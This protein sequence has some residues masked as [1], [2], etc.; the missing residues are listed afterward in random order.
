MDEDAKKQSGFLDQKNSLELSEQT[1]TSSRAW[2]EVRDVMSRDVVTVSKESPVVEAAQKMTARNISC[3]VVV[4]NNQVVGLITERDLLQKVVALGANSQVRKVCEIM[5]SPVLTV[6]PLMSIFEASAVL[7]THKIKRLPV[8]DN[9]LLVGIV[10]QTDL[11]RV[12]ASYGMWRNVGELMSH[13]VAVIK[14]D[15]LVSEAAKLMAER[16]I[17][18]VIALDEDQVVGIM[19]E[20]DM[21]KKIVALQKDPTK[22]WLHEVMS[23]PVL[24]IGADQ[25]VFEAL[26]LIEAKKIRR[27]VV[28]QGP[29]LLGIL[30]QT[31]IFRAIKKKLEDE[32][33]HHL[34]VL[35]RSENGI[36]AI[37][38]KGITTY[39]NP[40][41]QRLLDLENKEE[42]VGKPFL[43]E[44]FWIDPKDRT[45]LMGE[46]K[47]DSGIE[48]KELVL[49]SLKNKR[50][51]VTLFSTFTKNIHGEVNGTQG[52]L[53]DITDKKEL[54][55][56]RE[57]QEE[58]RRSNENLKRLNEAKSDF[59]SLVS[60]ELRAPMTVIRGRLDLVI[61]K[62]LGDVNEKQEKSLE[63]A[64]QNVDRLVRMVNNF[65]DLS[66]IEAG[67]MELRRDWIDLV[68]VIQFAAST[69]ANHA[70]EK[71]LALKV[72]LPFEHKKVFAE[73]D[74]LL[75]VLLNL[76]GNALKFTKQGEVKISVTEKENV[77][78]FMVADTGPGIPADELAVIFE[79]FGQS[80]RQGGSAKGTGLGL[81]LAE[82]FV[83]MHG[84]KL[85]VESK[86]GEGSK[87]FFAIPKL[88]VES[89]FLQ[90]IADAIK[91]A[92]EK[93]LNFCVALL[94]VEFLM[95]SIADV[96]L[97]LK[98]SVLKGLK[99]V[100]EDSLRHGGD[101]VVQ[102]EK[103]LM[104]LLTN[105]D[106]EGAEK[107]LERFILVLAHYL[108]K[109]ELQDQ[110]RF[111]FVSC[112]YPEDGF[113]EDELLVKLR[114][115]IAKSKNF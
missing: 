98:T 91:A 18:C 39:V 32:E 24:S 31:D 107:A 53:Y 16:N 38:L 74:R 25:S 101:T 4:E 36:F 54:V 17:S 41:L 27:L 94:S 49:C 96:A 106:R 111:I 52:I 28:M 67:R 83:K 9:G 42:L 19:T 33:A 10:T 75:Q 114:E 72:E 65:L 81:T 108:A 45:Q 29:R 102:G 15:S 85:W 92:S 6:S 103:E 99:A 105:C 79:K 109:K 59:V 1:L 112:A 14:K 69:F 63:L 7:E 71:K 13:A 47:R 8:V 61:S 21:M 3:S 2:L 55:A 77:F 64:I 86:L 44:R 70:Q 104:V 57:T 66:K 34:R 88:S 89:V 97:E 90:T 115:S 43:P 76:V 11:T 78:E 51:Y 113:S 80:K 48:I 12:L 20:R 40:A 30:T 110:I 37:D 68:R 58:L 82:Q 26:K 62:A 100:L 84:G 95:D 73:E 93:D 56:L 5:S 87:F 22:V 60:H 46:L 35:E 50:I 23:S